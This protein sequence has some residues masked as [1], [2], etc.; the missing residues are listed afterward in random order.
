MIEQMPFGTNSFAENPEH[1]VA[2]LLLL[3]TSGSMAE[4]VSNAGQDLGY[5]I[6]SD[7]QT[8]RAVS[9]GV[10]R[11][12]ELNA[13]LT[14]Y[15]ESLAADSLASKRVEVAIMTFGGHVQTVCDFTTVEGFQP[16][17][18]TG[19]GDTPMGEAIRQGLDILR[20]RK[21]LYKA[22]GISYY[23]PWVFLITDGGPTDEWRSAAEQV[24]Q[25]EKDK[26]FSF[27]AVG[28]E[29]A[30][31]DVLKQICTR[32]PLKLKGVRYRDLFLWLSASQSSVS[33]SAPG[34]TVPLVD[35]TAGPKGWASV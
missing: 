32:E 15:K 2:C 12:D 35:P 7:G 23:R 3:D 34:E 25:G 30:N 28:V 13:G 14:A 8:Y 4:I 19:S 29:G 21:E 31:F 1:R 26:A 27:F 17:T 24:K 10:T 18:L 33:R 11:I 9:G 5:T 6:Q 20:S 16:P 22:H